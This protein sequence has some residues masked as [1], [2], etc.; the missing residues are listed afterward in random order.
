MKTKDTNVR[1]A[2]FTHLTGRL[3][4]TAAVLLLGLLTYAPRATA[5]EVLQNGSFAA[6]TNYWQR[7]PE[8]AAWI[9]IWLP[10]WPDWQPIGTGTAN[11]HPV[12]GFL[13]PI[14]SQD[15]N[16]TNVAGAELIAKITL[17]KS[18]GPLG[19]T[20][21]IAIYADYVDADGLT[22]RI[23]LQNPADADLP[24]GISTVTNQITLPSSARTLVRYAISRLESGSFESS[25][26]SLDV[27]TG[28][29]RNGGFE[30]GD[31]TFWASTNLYVTNSLEAIDGTNVVQLPF[32]FGQPTY[33]SQNI[34]GRLT[35]GVA[36]KFS[37]WIFLSALGAGPPMQFAGPFLRVSSSDNMS[38]AMSDGDAYLSNPNIG[39]NL[40]EFTRVF[41]SDELSGPVYFGVMQNYG[42]LQPLIDG[43]S[44]QAVPPS[45]S[46]ELGLSIVVPGE[47][48]TNTAPFLL[49]AEV[50]N[51]T[52]TVSSLQF[53]ANDMLVGEGRV[54]PHGSWLFADGSHLGVMG[55]GGY[56]MV[57]CNLA[58]G[59][60]FFM[61]GAYTSQTN[62]SGMFQYFVGENM[63]GGAVSVVYSLDAADRLTAAITGDAPMGN[64]T[65]SNGTNLSDTVSYGYFWANAP[66]GS[67]AIT[68]RAVFGAGLLATSAPVNI[69]VIG[70]IPVAQPLLGLLPVASGHLG[71]Q[72]DA[73]LGCTYQVQ[74]S[75]NLS[76]TNWVNLGSS[77]IATKSPVA[78]TNAIST[79]ETRFFRVQAIGN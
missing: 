54:D 59:G 76:A 3:R 53:Y 19:P 9:L 24:Y 13:G 11:L 50:T 57:D 44:A 37:G 2:R 31:L 39:W 27:E 23:L 43:L 41:T 36:Y 69:T 30:T 63:F 61:N 1:T 47:G 22:N 45:N 17:S 29:V 58:S 66:A 71:L 33:L 21:S 60:M 65:L 10:T 56:E 14:V 48:E 4:V 64:R 25:G 6:G 26:V 79:G 12:H 38:A 20:N 5:A 51:L 70:S 8:L 15:L 68:A 72:W 62:F 35:A 16:V 52:A 42:M 28:I 78:V 34:A 55:G 46:P 67:Y 32:G 75:T 40:L 77:F 73:I 18:G 7:S 74:T 49:R